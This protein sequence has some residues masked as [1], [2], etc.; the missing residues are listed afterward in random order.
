MF[1]TN[2]K[3]CLLTLVLGGKSSQDFKEVKCL[4]LYLFRKCQNTDPSCSAK[5]CI[6]D[7]AALTIKQN[8]NGFLNTCKCLPFS[9]MH[10]KFKKKKNRVSLP[11]LL[12][13]LLPI[14]LEAISLLLKE[15]KN[16]TKIFMLLF[17]WKCYIRKV[18]CKSN[19]RKTYSWLVAI[20]CSNM[21]II[22]FLFQTSY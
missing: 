20:P 13:L 7:A 9:Q 22:C 1:L 8:K 5:T 14:T 11:C 4:L 15:K 3:S 18:M 12:F 6:L 21:G 16:G 17:L 10:L 2:H 19:T